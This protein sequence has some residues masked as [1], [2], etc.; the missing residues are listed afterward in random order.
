MLAPIATLFRPLSFLGIF[1]VHYF[2]GFASITW[3]IRITYHI[4]YL[5]SLPYFQVIDSTRT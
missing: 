2:L 5:G 4:R 1:K 3:I